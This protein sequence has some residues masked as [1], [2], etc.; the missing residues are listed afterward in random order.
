MNFKQSSL[1]TRALEAEQ[2]ETAQSNF[3]YSHGYLN[4]GVAEQHRNADVLIPQSPVAS[5]FQ[6]RRKLMQH[7]T[8]ISAF[9]TLY[10]ILVMKEENST[11]IHAPFSQVSI[12]L[13]DC[14]LW[15]NS[16]HANK[17]GN[18]IHISKK[19]KILLLQKSWFSPF[20]TS[21]WGSF[22]PQSICIVALCMCFK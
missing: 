22:T 5:F 4:S 18:A 15:K 1:D 19:I 8:G 12:L 11:P 13:T 17:N 3:L 16:Q 6:C 14:M 21:K 7:S 2:Q 20:L 9:L 10:A